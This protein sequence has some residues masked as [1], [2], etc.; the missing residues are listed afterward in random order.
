MLTTNLRTLSERLGRR[1]RV[2]LLVPSSNSVMEPDFYADLPDGVTLHTARMF[3]RDVT[4]AAEEEMLDVHFPK[5]L[6]ELATVQPDVVV[7][8]C[9]SAGALRG[10]AYDEQICRHITDVTE[11]PAVSVIASVRAALAAVLSSHSSVLVLS[12]YIDEVNE[13]I[14]ASLAADGISVAAVKGLGIVENQEIGAVHPQRIT[15]FAQTTLQD[16]AKDGRTPGALFLSCTNLR[17]KEARETVQNLLG[18]PVVTSNQAAFDAT[19]AVLRKLT[20]A[21]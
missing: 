11:S 14:R 4:V 20:T 1:L 2:G 18:L 8:G 6:H 7:F 19:V 16:V 10:N 9:T 3:L 15:Q 13:R 21:A 5:A 17:A 12:P